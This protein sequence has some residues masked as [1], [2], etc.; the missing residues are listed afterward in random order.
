MFASLVILLSGLGG[1]AEDLPSVYMKVFIMRPSGLVLQTS[2]HGLDAS[3]AVK[4]S[5][6]PGGVWLWQLGGQFPSLLAPP[7]GTCRSEVLLDPLHAP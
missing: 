5:L 2:F 4:V 3:Q 7:R 6:R 1:H